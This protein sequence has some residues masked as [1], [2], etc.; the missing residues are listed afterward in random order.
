LIERISP[1]H[2]T[3]FLPALV[4]LWDDQESE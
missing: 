1:E 4:A 3:H 2:R